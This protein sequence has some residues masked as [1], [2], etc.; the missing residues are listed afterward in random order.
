MQLINDVSNIELQKVIAIDQA[1]LNYAWNVEQWK[2][3]QSSYSETTYLQI[4]YDAQAIKSFALYMYSETEGLLHLLKIV[5]AVHYRRQGLG[6]NLIQGAMQ[7]LQKHKGSRIV[8]DVAVNNTSAISLY[9]KIGFRTI[10]TKR[11]FYSD[12]CD[13]LSMQWEIA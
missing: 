10:N 2:D 1:F 13:A 12:G 4:C 9:E 3:F 6:R 8:L 5:T 11:N 7:W